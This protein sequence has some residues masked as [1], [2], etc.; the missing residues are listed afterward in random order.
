MDAWFDLINDMCQVIKTEHLEPFPRE[1]SKDSQ[2]IEALSTSVE[3]I[4]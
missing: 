1:P 2:G 3:S 4:L